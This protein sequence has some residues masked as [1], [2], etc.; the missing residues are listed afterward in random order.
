[1]VFRFT[2]PATALLLL[3]AA[4]ALGQAPPSAPPGLRPHD[5]YE[6]LR[7]SSRR[8][9]PTVP[10]RPAPPTARDVWVPERDIQLPGVPGPVRVPGH[11][12]RRVSER[13][14]YAP[15][16]V[17]VT[18]DGTPVFIPGGVRPAPEPPQAP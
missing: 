17:G 15:P 1:M 3:T 10:P 12:E 14:V 7:E 13:E 8:P 16:L 9:L 5:P 2:I 6:A 18:P 4:V 11:W